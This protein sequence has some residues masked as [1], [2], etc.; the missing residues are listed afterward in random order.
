VRAGSSLFGRESELRMLDQLFDNIRGRGCSLGLTGGPGV[1][2]SALL[3]VAAER[4][5]ER[6]MLVLR[7]TG[8]QSE[9]LQAF[10]GLH[11]LLRPVLS[12]LDGLPA[13]Q[14]AAIQ[15]LNPIEAAENLH[16]LDGPKSGRQRTKTGHQVLSQRE[17]WASPTLTGDP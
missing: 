3:A 8:V 13:P 9:A 6:G 17:G 4:A 1:G 16:Q 5:T 7:A 2:K 10:A 14:R 15:A 12:H 11:Q